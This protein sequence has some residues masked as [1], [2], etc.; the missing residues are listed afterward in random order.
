MISIQKAIDTASKHHEDL[1]KSLH[2]DSINYL[3]RE[4]PYKSWEDFVA[5]GD[6]DKKL[7]PVI[8]VQVLANDDSDI[9]IL[10]KLQ[11][12]F[13]SLPEDVQKIKRS[14]MVVKYL[15]AF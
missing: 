4:F 10:E 14:V 3:E 7:T 9:Q 11:P 6:D 2:V 1:L 15:F 5:S 13:E 8:T 12:F